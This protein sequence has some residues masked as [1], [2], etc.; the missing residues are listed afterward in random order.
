MLSKSNAGEDLKQFSVT[1]PLLSNRKSMLLT[2]I[3]I[4][5][6]I[7]HSYYILAAAWLLYQLHHSMNTVV[8]ESM[9]VM[10]DLGVQLTTRYRSG[11]ETHTFIDKSKITSVIINEGITLYHTIYYMSFIVQEKD[12]MVLAF[13]VS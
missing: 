4:A 1:S 2:C 12:K 6:M 7:M 13:R 3:P 5:I 11:K 8:E 10:Q 9:L